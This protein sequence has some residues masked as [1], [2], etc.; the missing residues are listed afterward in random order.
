MVIV[1]LLANPS[2]KRDHTLPE[3]IKLAYLRFRLRAP[4]RSDRTAAC[5]AERQLTADG[6]QS[7]HGPNRAP[8]FQRSSGIAASQRRTDPQ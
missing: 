6:P 1:S 4:A 2:D 7:K 3:Q 5:G 8:S